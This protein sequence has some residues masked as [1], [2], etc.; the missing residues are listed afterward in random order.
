MK[1]NE[2]TTKK[3]IMGRI[4]W[5]KLA[6]ARETSQNNVSSNYFQP[7]LNCCYELKA[8]CFKIYDKYSNHAS[9]CNWCVCICVY[10][11]T[12]WA[13]FTQQHNLCRHQPQRAD[14]Q[15]VYRHVDPA[16]QVGV[17]VSREII[18]YWFCFRIKMEY[19]FTHSECCC[20]NTNKNKPCESK[21][22][23]QTE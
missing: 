14:R 2:T 10:I 11:H 15:T 12:L 17:C 23:H 5:T 18:K 9:L 8:D 7:N 22:A 6:L 21:G 4:T 20:R 19:L 16:A 13:G 3:T 1:L